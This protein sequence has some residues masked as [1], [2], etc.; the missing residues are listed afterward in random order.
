MTRAHF[1]WQDPFALS[2]MLTEE[3]R[4]I[5]DSAQQYCQDKLLPRVLMA[6]REEH[7]HR[8][9]MT[10]LGELGLLGIYVPEE[11]TVQFKIF[12]TTD[13]VYQAAEAPSKSK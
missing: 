5:R 1:D 9:I 2:A 7:F 3:E 10:E 11:Y 4:M 8:E 6:N 12:T 13:E